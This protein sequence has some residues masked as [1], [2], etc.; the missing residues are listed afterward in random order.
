M[1]QHEITSAVAQ[2]ARISNHEDA[3]RAVRS[4]VQV[5]GARLSG[6]Q[7]R[8]LAS[9]LPTDLAAVLPTEGAGERFGVEE[10]YRRVAEAEGGQCT[11][12]QAR[13]HARATFAALKVGLTGNEYDHIA[14]QLPADY[15]D[16]L[17]TESV[18]HH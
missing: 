18:Q 15:E 6:G 8:N 10:F 7:T 17:G 3:E 4:T 12:Q 1:K 13:Q 5:L 9:Q 16:L 14:S 11:Q 2:S